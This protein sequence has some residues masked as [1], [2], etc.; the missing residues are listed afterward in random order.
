M[1]ET[2]QQAPAKRYR[3]SIG[4]LHPDPPHWHRG[5][6]PECRELVWSLACLVPLERPAAEALALWM[7]PGT[8]GVRIDEI[9]EGA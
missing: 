7:N 2:T 3:V 5:M 9:P 4:T 8:V 1:G 6:R